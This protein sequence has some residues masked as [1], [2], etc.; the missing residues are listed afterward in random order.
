MHKS[1]DYMA[2]KGDLEKAYDR[3]EWLVIK[4]YFLE[5]VFSDKL[6]N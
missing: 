4:N 5:L 2:K 6:T 1:W 3:L